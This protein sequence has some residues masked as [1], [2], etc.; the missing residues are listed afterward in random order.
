M[1]WWLGIG[2]LVIFLYW[3]SHLA[4]AVR[5]RSLTNA[6]LKLL[7]RVGTTMPGVLNPHQEQVAAA[8][9]AV[10]AASP[11]PSVVITPSTW[12]RANLEAA[13]A[14]MLPIEAIF[15]R[16]AA[17]ELTALTAVLDAEQKLLAHNRVAFSPYPGSS[18]CRHISRHTVL[19][20]TD[21]QFKKL[22]P[23]IQFHT[24][25]NRAYSRSWCRLCFVAFEDQWGIAVSGGH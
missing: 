7:R 10:S 15:E 12:L 1:K 8:G 25:G 19:K 11:R 21:E 23:Q 4:R 20:L 9:Q 3:F 14:V 13:R 5:Q 6:L 16:L 2:L 18:A 22:I 24:Q 17:S